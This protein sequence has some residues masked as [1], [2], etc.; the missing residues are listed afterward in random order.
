MCCIVLKSY[1]LCIRKRGNMELISWEPVQIK[2]Q[3]PIDQPSKKYS[4]E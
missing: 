4:H 1:Y 2:D 3:K